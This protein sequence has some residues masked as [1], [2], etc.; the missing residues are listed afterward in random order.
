MKGMFQHFLRPKKCKA[1]SECRDDTFGSKNTWEAKSKLKKEVTPLKLPYQLSIVK[2]V[3]SCSSF[4]GHFFLLQPPPF[5][6]L[7]PLLLFPQAPP[8]RLAYSSSMASAYFC[9]AVR[10]SSCRTPSFSSFS[11]EGRWEI[12]SLSE[13]AR[14]CFAS[15]GERCQFLHLLPLFP[16]AHSVFLSFCLIPLQDMWWGSDGFNMYEPPSAS[17]AGRGRRS[18]QA[19]CSL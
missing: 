8:S 2:H 9:S 4:F 12:L 5:A 6:T 7:P 17:P 3:I 13:S 1:Y 15:C 11:G 16:P 19:G 18:I 14:M 10:G